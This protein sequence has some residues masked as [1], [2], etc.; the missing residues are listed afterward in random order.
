MRKPNPKH[1]EETR[2]EIISREGVC[3]GISCGDCPLAGE[4]KDN[5]GYICQGGG[6]GNYRQILEKLNQLEQAPK[7]E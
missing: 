6:Q 3:Y 5:F 4:W 2:K 7:T 1:F